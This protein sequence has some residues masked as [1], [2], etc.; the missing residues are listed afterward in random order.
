MKKI[1]IIGYGSIARQHACNIRKVFRRCLIGVYKKKHYHKYKNI[2]KVFFNLKEAANWNAEVIIIAS[3]ANTHLEYLKYFCDSQKPHVTFLLEKPATAT[4]NGKCNNFISRNKIIVG[5]DLRFTRFLSVIKKILNNDQSKLGNILYFSARVGQ[6][7]PTWRHS[8]DFRKDVSARRDRAGGVLR[9]L[10]HE[11]DYCIDLFGDIKN[12]SSVISSGCWLNLD[13]EDKAII[14][15]EFGISGASISGTIELDMLSEKA[16]RE[17]RVETSNGRIIADWLSGKIRVENHGFVTE[18]LLV[19]ECASS[20]FNEIVFLKQLHHSGM[21]V[22][23]YCN[24][25][26]GLKISKLIDIIES[27]TGNKE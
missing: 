5:Y 17:L 7:L 12:I 9:E 18:E 16:F 26:Q 22:N 25:E 20:L 14:Q 4:V 15:G 3:P 1:L 11:L 2:D 21:L 24:L 27:Q 6:A 10:S 13:V 8:K 19:Q 23:D